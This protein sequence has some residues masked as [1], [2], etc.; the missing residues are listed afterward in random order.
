MDD[1]TRLVGDHVTVCKCAA[2]LRKTLENGDVTWAC[3]VVYYYSTYYKAVLMGGRGWW[4]TCAVR[5]DEP[6]RVWTKSAHLCT[7]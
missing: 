1:V 2:L 7:L 5:Y 4:R 6:M 3:C